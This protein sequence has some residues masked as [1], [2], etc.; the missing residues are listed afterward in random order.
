MHIDWIWLAVGLVLAW[1]VIP[2]ALQ[3]VGGGNKQSG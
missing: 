3:L 2:M 1:F